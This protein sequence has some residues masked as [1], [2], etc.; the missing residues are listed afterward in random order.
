M[1]RKRTTV[2][3]YEYDYCG[4]NEGFARTYKSL[5][6]VLAMARRDAMPGRP[7]R[8]DVC[9]TGRRRRIFKDQSASRN[10]E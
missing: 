8:I 3:V 2:P 5:R 7:T 9:D 10:G 1:P 4:P 6:K